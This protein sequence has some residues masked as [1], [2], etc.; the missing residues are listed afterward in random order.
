[1][2]VSPRRPLCRIWACFAI[3]SISSTLGSPAC[4]CPPP[5]TWSDPQWPSLACKLRFEVTSSQR[6]VKC[7]HMGISH[8]PPFVLP[9]SAR[10]RVF[11]V[12]HSLSPRPYCRC[13]NILFFHTVIWRWMVKHQGLCSPTQAKLS[14]SPV[15]CPERNQTSGLLSVFDPLPSPPL[16]GLRPT[17]EQ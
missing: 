17:Q 5:N 2:S 4:D 12:P 3:V 9:F 15:L 7:Q 13:N 11:C 8:F 16:L 10:W 6:R 1:M 14:L